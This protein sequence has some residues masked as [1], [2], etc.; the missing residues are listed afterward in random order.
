MWRTPLWSKKLANWHFWLG[1]L[2]II[3]YAVPMYISGFTQGL[4]WK[5]FNPDG[6]LLWKNWLDTV[7]A[8]IPYFK[9]RF[10]GG[11]FYISGAILMV[12][13]VIKTVKAGSFQ[14]EVPAEAPALANIGR[15]RKEGEGIH[16]WLERTPTL[17]A[18]LAFI[19][20]AIGGL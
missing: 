8:I 4:M 13:N 2:G 17:L 16:L 7:T 3:F 14:K 9:M 12:V 20:V 6:T 19:T 1:T 11:I 10:L 15:A 5:Q 18:I